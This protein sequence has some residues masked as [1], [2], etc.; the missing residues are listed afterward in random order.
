MHNIIVE[1]CIILQMNYV[2]Y[3]LVGKYVWHETMDMRKNVCRVS[4]LWFL[5]N[6][7]REREEREGTSS[8]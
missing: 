3:Y 7:T 6:S 1:V 2:E 5:I 8:D 4:P